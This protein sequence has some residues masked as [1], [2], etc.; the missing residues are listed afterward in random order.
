MKIFSDIFR[1]ILNSSLSNNAPQILLAALPISTLLISPWASIVCRNAPLIFFNSNCLTLLSLLIVSRLSFSYSSTQ[2]N[3]HSIFFVSP[4]N[5]SVKDSSN[6]D[7]LDLKRF[8]IS[9]NM[10][11]WSLTFKILIGF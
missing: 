3:T 7:L 10:V 5:I 2:F 1:L 11:M 9:I 8:T 6:F 4:D